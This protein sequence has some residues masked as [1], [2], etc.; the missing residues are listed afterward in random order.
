MR[1]K[2]ERRELESRAVSTNVIEKGNQKIKN[3]L[4]TNF[5]YF[6]FRKA[7]HLVVRTVI[8]GRNRHLLKD[9]NLF[10]AKKKLKIL[11]KPRIVP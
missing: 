1:E 9:P 11:I 4:I 7:L 3:K 2:N 10:V 5:L 6:L 8:M